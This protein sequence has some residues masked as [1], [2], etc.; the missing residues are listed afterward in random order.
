M[1]K[2]I[3]SRNEALAME[4]G[5]RVLPCGLV[6]SPHRKSEG[7]TISGWNDR[8]YIF[9]TIRSNGRFLKVSVAR[10]QALQKF[11][12]SL[13]YD[14]AM[15][16][17]HL[18]GNS[19]D[20]SESNIG[21]GTASQNAMD[22]A[23]N[24]RRRVSSMANNKHDHAKIIE[25]HKLGMSYGRIMVEFGISS[26]GTVSFIVRQ[27]MTLAECDTAQKPEKEYN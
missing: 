18:N 6:I 10:L 21:I 2:S 8:G 11:G 26:K 14:A 1:S 7:E 20:N 23:P 27:S 22:K 17:R 4:R 5:Y 19:S 24:V 12:E 15:E 3:R 9:F 13:V 25:A 16:V